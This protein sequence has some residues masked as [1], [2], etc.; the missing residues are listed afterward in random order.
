MY[1]LCSGYVCIQTSICGYEY[2]H[3]SGC[4]IKSLRNLWA[5]LGLAFEVRHA[6]SASDGCKAAREPAESSCKKSSN[7]FSP[8]TGRYILCRESDRR[9]GFVEMLGSLM[10]VRSFGSL[11]PWVP[12]SFAGNLWGF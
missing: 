4:V 11:G 3:A 12:E 2:V 10:L 9:Q 7:R 1:I 8:T 5:V 6:A